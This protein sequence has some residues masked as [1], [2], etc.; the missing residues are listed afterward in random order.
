MPET[1]SNEISN[2]YQQLLIIYAISFNWYDSLLHEE[3]QLALVSGQVEEMY[4]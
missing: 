3:T 4:S 2:M 1:I